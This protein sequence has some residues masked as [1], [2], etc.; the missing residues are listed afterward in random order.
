MGNLN[1]KNQKSS[2][3]VELK[4]ARCGWQVTVQEIK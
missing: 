4:R 1:E 3:K 2:E